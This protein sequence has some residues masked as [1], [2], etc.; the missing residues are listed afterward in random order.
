MCD[1]P[2]G[3]GANNMGLARSA[4]AVLIV[5]LL[6]IT[7]VA[8]NGVIAADRTVTNEAFVTNT[9]EDEGAYSTVQSIAADEAED[10]V[11]EV[12]ES[13]PVPIDPKRAVNETL[14]QSYIQNQTEANLERIFDYMEGNSS[15]LIL[16][17]DLKPVKQNVGSLAERRI[18]ELTVSEL[19]EAITQN[20]D[21]SITVQN[22]TFDLGIVSNMSEGPAEY[23]QARETFR[24]DVREVVISQLVE[25]A[26]TTWSNDELLLVVG[27]DPDDYT[28]AEKE[29]YVTEH[30]T[31]IKTELETRIR[32]ESGDE[33]DAAIDEQL[34]SINER[35]ETN[36][37]ATV[38]ESL[39]EQYEPVAEPATEMLMVGVRGLTTDMSFETFDS[40]LNTAKSNLAANVSI[41]VTNML[42][43][44]F[45]DRQVLFPDPTSESYPEP[46]A[47]QQ[48]LLDT[49]KQGFDLV[50]LLSLLLP[51][52]ALVLIGLLYV[53]TRSIGKT[54][55]GAGLTFFSV[56][57]S[58]FVV[59][60]LVPNILETQVESQLEGGDVPQ[61]ALDLILGIFE[62][63]FGLLAAQSLLLAFIGLLGLGVW[64]AD[65]MDLIWESSETEDRGSSD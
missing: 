61:D 63:V 50:S 24:D 8:G 21:L 52:I 46:T 10:R 5:V 31:E 7:L 9:L 14:T 3:I 53:V 25:E 43:A 32:E 54:A 37:Q 45:E 30:E 33:I 13:I 26:Y 35:V 34:S 57:L 29:Q 23:Q 65:R 4:L 62:Q 1:R 40:N 58:W 41:V 64:L 12:E 60:K 6:S 47:D 55:F 2:A 15:E 28:E 36:V 18:N 44:E 11:S 42:D 51:L 22:V 59:A 49:V 38:N 19:L 16:W 27:E 48:E 39:T 17:V 56:G 20:Q